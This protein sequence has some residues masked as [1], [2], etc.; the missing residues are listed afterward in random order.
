[1]L[2]AL[3]AAPSV[4]PNELDAIFAA[5]PARDPELAKALH[6]TVDRRTD[7]APGS[8]DEYRAQAEPLARQARRRRRELDLRVEERAVAAA[9]EERAAAEARL[10]AVAD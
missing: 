3:L 7:Y 5:W 6:A 4:G 9:E 8:R 1:M 2:D 10:A